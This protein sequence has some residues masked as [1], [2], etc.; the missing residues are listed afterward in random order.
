MYLFNN[1]IVWVYSIY[2]LNSSYVI[3]WIFIT[4]LFIFCFS[5]WGFL[6]F[7][8]HLAVCITIYIPK[9]VYVTCYLLSSSFLSTYIIFIILL[10]IAYMG[11]SCFVDLR[12]WLLVIMLYLHFI[13]Y[14]YA[15]QI[16][17][18]TFVLLILHNIP[19]QV[20]AVF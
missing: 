17:Y 3:L 9:L 19:L 16:N 6:V 12:L 5:L 10:N 13:L 11:T 14:N 7:F 1:I 15:I 8:L 4:V 18:T 20:H 2:Y